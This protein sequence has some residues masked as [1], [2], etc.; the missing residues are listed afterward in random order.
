SFAKAESLTPHEIAFLNDKNLYFSPDKGT[1]VEKTEFH[2]LED[3]LKLLIRKFSP[4]FDFKSASWS[5]FMEFKD[6]RDSLV[7]PR[8]ID[9]ETSVKDYQGRL[10]RGLTGIIDIMNCLSKGVFGKPL[11]KKLLDLIPE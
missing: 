3:K 8:Q 6:F 2:R 1:L 5:R 4:N 7:H 11:R 10:H 9:D